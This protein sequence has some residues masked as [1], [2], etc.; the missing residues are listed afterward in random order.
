MG[1]GRA[2]GQSDQEILLMHFN[3][4]FYTACKLTQDT[5]EAED[6]VQETYLKAYRALAQLQH[7]DQCK[8]WLFRIML[9]TW[10]N[11]QRRATR[12]PLLMEPT[13]LSRL[14][15]H[16]AFQHPWFLPL[17]PEDTLLKK[18]MRLELDTALQELPE[19]LRLM[20]FLV[21]VYGLTYEESA[22]VLDLPRGTVMSRLY[23]ARRLLEEYFGDQLRKPEEDA[24]G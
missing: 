21:D 24:N 17:N 3:A 23:R 2:W 12:A 16:S 11:L 10:S 6:L 5:S 1:T 8:A 13:Q 18:E 20:I 4:L 7:P 22:G 9:N 15:E 19:A 14:R